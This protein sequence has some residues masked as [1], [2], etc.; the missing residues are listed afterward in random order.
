MEG[1]D[2]SFLPF[3]KLRANGVQR[4]RLTPTSISPNTVMPLAL[5]PS[6]TGLPPAQPASP[7]ASAR[8]A[9]HRMQ[10]FMNIP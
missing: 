5:L 2:V 1:E 6:F 10:I 7:A 3:D 8:A 9:H 4:T